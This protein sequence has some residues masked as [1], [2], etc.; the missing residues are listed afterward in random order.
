[1]DTKEVSDK[2]VAPCF[3]NGLEAYDS[4]INLGE[5]I[6]A[7]G[8]E[9][10]FVKFIINPE[11]DDVELAVVLG[12]PFMRLT[13]GIADFGNETITIY[14]KLD[15]LL[16]SAGEEEK[17][18]DEWDLLLDDI[19]FGDIL[20]IK[21]VVLSPFVCKMGKSNRNKR[22]QL[23]K[24]QLINSD[25]GPLMSFGK[26]LTQ[27]EAQRE[28]LAINICERYSLL[29]EERPVIK[30]IGLFNTI[31]TSLKALDE[32]FSV[33]NYVRKFLKALHPKWR[34]KVTTIEE[35]KDLSSLDLDE[36]RAKSIALKAKKE[37]SDYETLTFGSKDEEYVMAD[38]KKGK[39]DRLCFRCGDLNHL[40]SNCPNPTRNKDQNAFIGGSWSDSKN[41]AKD[42]TCLMA[43]SSNVVTLNYSYY[44]DNAS[45]ND[46][47]TMKIEYNSLC[48][49]SLKTI[50]KR[51][52]RDLL[53]K[54][55]LELNEKLKKPERSKEINIACKSCQ[56][57]KLENAK[58]KETQVKFVKF[59]K[60]ANLLREMLNNQK[61][62]SCIIGLGF[63][64][65]KASTSETKPMS[66]VGSSAEKATDGSTIKVHGSNKPR[67]VSRKVVKN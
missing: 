44:S 29:E 59:D 30:T 11:E 6:V 48:E 61:S 36:E 37:S 14:L 57:L 8:G 43:Q 20:D 10:Y 7:L 16:D 21:G 46:N 65:N 24:Y 56:E 34:E 51:T 28:A 53:E 45:S 66:F 17:I 12:R 35:S 63:D 9:I 50:N 3:V 60:S 15:P 41:D 33:K 62:S 42:K 52:K 27:K 2:Y 55:V 40:I 13:K 4:E 64:S 1:M 22:K 54:E 19:V 58:L 5:L 23:D 38:E 26:P 32:G 67:S 47:D 25:M 31:I 49:I 18:G 39:S